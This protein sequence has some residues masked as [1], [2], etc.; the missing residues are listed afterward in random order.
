MQLKGKTA[1][2]DG[3]FISRNLDR[4]EEAGWPMI[5]APHGRPAAS[6]CSMSGRRIRIEFRKYF[7]GGAYSDA[8][9]MGRR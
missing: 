5:V 8:Q 2:A 9:K 3:R 6:M 4:A 7:A 1:F